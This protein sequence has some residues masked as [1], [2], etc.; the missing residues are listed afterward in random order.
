MSKTIIVKKE[1][2][3]IIIPRE[4]DIHDEKV[5]LKKEGNVL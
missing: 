1:K 3:K 2:G 4:M 5:Y